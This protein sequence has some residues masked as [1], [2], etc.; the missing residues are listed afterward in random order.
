MG[1]SFPSVGLDL[2]HPPTGPELPVDLLAGSL[3]RRQVA[4]DSAHAVAK[5]ST[6]ISPARARACHRSYAICIPSHASGVEPKAFD[7]RIAISTET[8]FARSAIPKAPAA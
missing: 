1:T 7:S 6:A 4:P 2:N 8:P 3:V 5:R